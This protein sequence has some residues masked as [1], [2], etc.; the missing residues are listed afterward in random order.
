ML[1]PR[2]STVKRN[3]LGKA[4]AIQNPR[5]FVPN[6]EHQPVQSAFRFRQAIGALFMRET[7]GTGCEGER[8][9][10]QPHYVAVADIDRR[11]SKPIATIPP[12]LCIDQPFA[13]QFRKYDRQKLRGNVLRLGDIRQGHRTLAI[14]VGKMLKRADSVTGLLG[15]H[16]S[17]IGRS[18]AKFKRQRRDSCFGVLWRQC[19][20]SWA[21]EISEEAVHAGRRNRPY[22]RSEI[23]LRGWIVAPL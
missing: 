23:A 16:T 17:S 4:D 8:P 7:A 3:R 13:G 1:R 2:H 9:A 10:S 12:A 20:A 21:R 19:C 6:A 18:V 15:Q 11:Q 22:R 5:R 14:M